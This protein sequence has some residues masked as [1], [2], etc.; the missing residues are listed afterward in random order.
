M[1]GGFINGIEYPGKALTANAAVTY[2]GTLVRINTTE[3]EIVLCGAGERPDGYVHMGSIS[4]ATGSPVATAGSKVAVK[5]LVN[6]TIVEIPLPATHAALTVGAE[7]ET[8]ADGCVIIKAGAGEI[9]GKV[10]VAV[11]ENVGGYAKIWVSQRTA[12][13]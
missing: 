12:S 4:M 7:V 5:G 9:V 11:G 2:P 13:A 8:A 3:G 6:G 1:S 10:L